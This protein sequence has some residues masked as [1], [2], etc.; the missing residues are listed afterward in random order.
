VFNSSH[1]GV[2]ADCVGSPFI[3][4]LVRE[5]E[6]QRIE[7][8]KLDR[9]ALLEDGFLSESRGEQRGALIG[10]FLC[11]VPADGAALV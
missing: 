6:H 10:V 9:R 1:P 2:R 5:L 11:K 8:R 3:E 4:Y 7:V